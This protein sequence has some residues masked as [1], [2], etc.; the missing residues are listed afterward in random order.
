MLLQQMVPLPH[1]YQAR[2]KLILEE[3]RKANQSQPAIDLYTTTYHIIVANPPCSK[4][5][6]KFDTPRYSTGHG[7]GTTRGRGRSDGRGCFGGHGRGTGGS[8]QPWYYSQ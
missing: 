7:R 3:T 2:S 1:V 8:H 6:P 5:P 4:P